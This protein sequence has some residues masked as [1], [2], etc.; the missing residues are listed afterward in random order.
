MKRALSLCLVL[1][2]GCYL[3]H[4]RGEDAGIDERDTSSECAPAGTYSMRVVTTG[5]GARE[6]TRELTIPPEVGDHC[7]GS[8]YRPSPCVWS[9][10]EDCPI[11]DYTVSRSWQIDSRNGQVSAEVERIG[12][13]GWTGESCESHESWTQR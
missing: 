4:R 12:T 6:E 3:S 8:I 2:S 9:V 13:S 11:P 7:T 10:N 5:C 1:S